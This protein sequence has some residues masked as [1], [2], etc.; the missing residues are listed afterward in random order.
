MLKNGRT[1]K[2]QR[3]TGATKQ[4]LL[5]KR[6]VGLNSHMATPHPS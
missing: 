4:N 6:R 3:Q 5:K 1:N 2:K